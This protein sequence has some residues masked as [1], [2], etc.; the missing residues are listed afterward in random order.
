M[1]MGINSCLFNHGLEESGKNYINEGSNDE[2]G[3]LHNIV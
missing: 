2:L 1:F 3:I